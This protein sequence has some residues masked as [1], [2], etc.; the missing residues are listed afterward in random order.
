[1]CDAYAYS[2]AAGTSCCAVDQTIQSEL[3]SAS[4]MSTHTHTHTDTCFCPV[5]RSLVRTTG[6]TCRQSIRYCHRKQVKVIPVNIYNLL[7]FWR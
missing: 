4:L 1:M 7:W 6:N 5:F 2:L 3:P